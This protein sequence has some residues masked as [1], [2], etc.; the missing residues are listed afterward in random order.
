M[1]IAKVNAAIAYKGIEMV[2]GY[3]YFYFAILPGFSDSTYT[4]RSIMVPHFNR[5]T[6]AQWIEAAS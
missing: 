4:P 6:V 3:G 2:K 1:T 5:M